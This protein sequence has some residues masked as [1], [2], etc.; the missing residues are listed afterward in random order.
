MPLRPLV[1]WVR[2]RLARA[3]GWLARGRTAPPE[4]QPDSNAVVDS[5]A[6]ETL[7]G[8][9]VLRLS[10]NSKWRNTDTGARRQLEDVLPQFHLRPGE[11]GLSFYRVN[12]EE[13]I[14]H[15]AALYSLTLRDSPAHFEYV[16][17]PLADLSRFSLSPRPVP[18]HHPYLSERHFEADAP[19]AEDC[20]LLAAAFWGSKNLKIGRVT[21][22]ILVDYVVT[23][24]I[25]AQV[26][27]ASRWRE[28]LRKHRA[29]PP[30]RGGPA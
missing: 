12:G 24:D 3:R 16:Q 5:V 30:K 17:I 22:P 6:P 9:L 26:E 15:I 4:P 1:E 20:R 21:L 19:S 29:K 28:H 8:H 25:D 18:E 27:T 14:A 2:A 13:E 11:A 23:N 7:P 10:S